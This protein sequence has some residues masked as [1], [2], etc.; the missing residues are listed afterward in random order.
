MPSFDQPSFFTNP[1]VE[2]FLSDSNVATFDELYNASPHAPTSST[3]VDLP[4]GNALDNFEPFSTSSSISLVDVA[5]DIVESPNELVVPFSSHLTRMDVKNAFLNGDLEEE[6]YMKQPPGLN[7]PLNNTARGMVL[8][9]L[10][11]DDMI[12]TVDDMIVT[13][14]DTA[15]T[16]SNDGY[17]LSQVNYASDLVSKVELSDSKSVSTPFEPNV[18]L[19]PMDSFPL[20]YPT[21]YW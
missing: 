17:P 3:E 20:S 2:L 21:R 19:T 12:L 5:F 15:V 6:V 13:G 16:S 9:L 10:Y 4:V 8:L 18:K 11:I 14:D 1:S 7:R